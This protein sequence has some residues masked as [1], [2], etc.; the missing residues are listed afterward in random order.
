[1]DDMKTNTAAWATGLLVACLALPMAAVLGAWSLFDVSDARPG[2]LAYYLGVPAGIRDVTGTFG[3][4]RPARFRWKGRDGLSAPFV[5]M[6]YG[7]QLPP[8]EALER[9]AAALTPLACQKDGER[10]ATDSSPHTRPLRC[11]HPDVLAADIH[12]ETA[13]PCREVSLAF[14]LND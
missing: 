13:G 3:E 9:H 8:D 6:H 14:T 7:S 12:V 2:G 1:M 10:A 11:A 5:V 4:C